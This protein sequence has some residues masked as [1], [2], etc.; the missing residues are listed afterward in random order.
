[1]LR[2]WKLP[3]TNCSLQLQNKLFIFIDLL[4]HV[5]RQL[6]PAK[7]TLDRQQRNR[8][9]HPKE[10]HFQQHQGSAALNASWNP[11]LYTPVPLVPW[12]APLQMPFTLYAPFCN[13]YQLALMQQGPTI[14]VP[15]VQ[16]CAT[17]QFQPGPMDSSVLR[18]QSSGSCERDVK[19]PV[20]SPPTEC[21]MS[22]HPQAAVQGKSVESELFKLFV[23][24]QVLTQCV[25]PFE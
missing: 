15:N 4:L 7:K 1:M 19:S 18:T 25:T 22:L 16:G 13:P 8:V 23:L 5:K 20:S 21:S 17:V 9:L 3:I 2:V 6:Y 24:L 10:K 12:Q 11:T 14:S